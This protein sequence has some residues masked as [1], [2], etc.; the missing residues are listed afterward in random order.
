MREFLLGVVLGLLISG[1]MRGLPNSTDA[2]YRKAIEQCERS[3]PRDKH[4]V[5]TGIEAK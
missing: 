1:A 2:L 4:C 5:I 3:I